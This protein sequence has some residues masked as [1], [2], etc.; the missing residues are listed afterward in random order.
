[1]NAKIPRRPLNP[2]GGTGHPQMAQR[3]GSM[4]GDAEIFRPKQK[5][6]RV[7]IYR[8]NVSVIKPA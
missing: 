5:F 7:E 3:G 6:Y 2:A 4:E 1:V 8:H